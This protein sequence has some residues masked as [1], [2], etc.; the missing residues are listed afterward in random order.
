MPLT[1]TTGARVHGRRYDAIVVGSGWAGSLVARHLG[2]QGW[3][4]LV[5]EAGNGGTDTWAGFQDSLRTFYTAPL[6]VP[7]SAYRPNRAAPFPDVLDLRADD[8][9]GFS[10]CGYFV[11][12]G[13]MPY[14]T[15][16]LR[17]L[18]GAGM[19]WLGAIPRMHPEDFSTRAAFHYGRDWPLT[20]AD[21]QQYFAEAERLLGAAGDGCEQ[22]R[23]GVV[24][25][26][27]YEYPMQPI[28]P[29]WQ[30]EVF[31][32]RLDGRE[33]ADRVAGH[34]Y[35]LRVYGLPQA[36]NSTPNPRYE[37]G[38]GYRPR[39]AAGLP[40]YGERCV[41]NA[42]CVP[43]CPVQAKSSPLRLQQ[44]FTDSVHLATRCVVTRVLP[45][46]GGLARGVEF[47][48]YGD[49]AAPVSEVYTAEADIVVLAAHAIENAVLLLASDMANSSGYVG[50]HLMDHPTLLS[51]GLTPRGR[52]V[53]PYRGP[54]HTSGLE[55]FRFGPGRARRAPFRI[56]IGN[57]G[58]SWATGAPFSSAAQMLGLGGDSNGEIKTGGLFGPWLRH[59]LGDTLSRQVQL[60]IAVEQHA[61]PA[62]RVTINPS[63]YRDDL[64]NPRPVIHYDLDDH[65]R[66]GLYAARQV[67]RSVFTLLGVEDHT[68]LGPHDGKTPLGHFRHSS[69]PGHQAE[70]LT[71][72][73]AGHGAGTHIMGTHPAT[74]VVDRDQRTHDHPN[75]YAVGCG[76]MPSIG[77]SNPTITMA[78]L[79][80]RSAERI[81]RQLAALH[82][83][84]TSSAPQKHHPKEVTRCSPHKP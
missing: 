11:Q 48:E 18:G 35:R 17:A 38:R 59:T 62:N 12:T 45:G 60:Q 34:D 3:K 24:A 20:A 19:H 28:P 21:L 37:Q 57:W 76:S 16:Y 80:L 53:W 2:L 39:G 78:A 50:C 66:D 26:P 29:S 73:G 4:V 10:S 6:K 51:W 41:G 1:T 25:G 23:L 69:D 32:Q 49:P 61:D 42:S 40:N 8:K 27:G 64:G 70:D 30:D 75:L 5:L 84:V 81:D 67:A 44:D 36:R 65:V 15:D 55:C 43:I 79:A 68:R 7:N 74:S 47:R 82:Q 54:G 46:R 52:P 9:G 31:R 77:T 58:W 83:A 13:P 71:Y 56:E 22:H 72:H 33:V 14:G 63:R